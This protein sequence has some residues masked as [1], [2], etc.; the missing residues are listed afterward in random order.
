MLPPNATIH[1]TRTEKRE[2]WLTWPAAVFSLSTAGSEA[3]IGQFIVRG[4]KAEFISPD[5][6]SSFKLRR[7]FWGYRWMY[8]GADEQPFA[9]VSY[10]FGKP[11]ITFPD[12]TRYKMQL[13]RRWNIFRKARPGE[14]E[15]VA[16]F[17]REDTPVMVLQNN[18]PR[19]LFA[20][21]AFMPMSGDISTTLG[22]MRL[23]CGMLLL[24]Q[25]A[26]AIRQAAAG[27]AVAST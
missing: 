4:G 21:E 7:G 5:G 16:T 3:P 18:H 8:D 6:R 22:D 1:F 12:D 15:H 14:Y 25:A 10:G 11:V 19:P 13:K 9:R 2:N 26:I 24:F 17:L 23:I 27:G 20:G